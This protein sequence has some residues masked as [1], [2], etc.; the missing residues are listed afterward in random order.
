MFFSSL[1]LM[2]SALTFTY[3]AG[4]SQPFDNSNFSEQTLYGG[5]IKEYSYSFTEIRLSYFESRDYILRCDL[6]G[7]EESL[8][9]NNNVIVNTTTIVDF[10]TIIGE[11][12]SSANLFTI[13]LYSPYAERV[14]PSLFVN[15]NN[16]LTLFNHT[17]Y[18]L[19]SYDNSLIYDFEFDTSTLNHDFSMDLTF[20]FVY[21]SAEDPVVTGDYGDGYA[22]GYNQGYDDGYTQGTFVSFQ[23]SYDNGYNDGYRTGYAVGKNDGINISGY[24]FTSLF[25]SISDTPILMI[26]RLFGFE[27]FGTSVMA[28][29]MSLF[30]ALV[31]IKVIKRI[32]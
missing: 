23:D 1:A 5:A 20:Y 32:L 4:E 18:T 29:F 27:I 22:D 13:Y 17:T 28:I 2:F 25:A 26:R 6:T 7:S 12:N 19:S 24:N 14:A 31:V 3:V 8:D 10:I 9:S 21:T 15:F 11:Y 16:E 30:T